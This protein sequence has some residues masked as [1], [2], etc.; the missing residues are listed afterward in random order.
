MWITTSKLIFAFTRCRV[1]CYSGIPVNK[2]EME[3]LRDFS[4]GGS[5][6]S[7]STME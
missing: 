1:I 3:F 4:F 7:D 2:A 6:N 5:Q